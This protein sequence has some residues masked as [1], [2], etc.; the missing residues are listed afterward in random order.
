MIRHAGVTETLPQMQQMKRIRS[1]N[2]P[3]QDNLHCTGLL[4]LILVFNR[5]RPDCD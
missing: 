3:F 5:V 4:F 1:H 2:Q